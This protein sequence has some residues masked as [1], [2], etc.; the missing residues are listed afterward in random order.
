[1]TKYGRLPVRQ[2][3]KVIGERVAKPAL[4]AGFYVFSKMGV[5][6]GKKKMN[7]KPY[8]N[9][10]LY[11]FFLGTI[12]GVLLIVGLLVS[13]AAASNTAIEDSGLLYEGLG[14]NFS[15]SYSLYFWPLALVAGS[16]VLS[17]RKSRPPNR[18]PKR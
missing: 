7:K 11:I 18:Q 2:D 10:G 17:Q 13:N 3:S 16:P 14:S 8:K 15:V 4:G 12:A 5:G 6:K 1:M 9:I